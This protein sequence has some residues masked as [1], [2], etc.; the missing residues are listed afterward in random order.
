M[1]LFHRITAIARP[2]I[3]QMIVDRA[4]MNLRLSVRLVTLGGEGVVAVDPS[5]GL[6]WVDAMLADL[7][8]H[9]PNSSELVRRGDAQTQR[10]CRRNRNAGLAG[11]WLQGV[12]VLTGERSGKQTAQGFA[13]AAFGSH[14]GTQG[15]DTA[16]PVEQ[17][18]DA[19]L[20]AGTG[21]GFAAGLSGQR[22]DRSF[23]FEAV[24]MLVGALATGMV[25]VQPW[26]TRTT[27][28]DELDSAP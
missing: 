9:G 7:V 10:I 16:V 23:V 20:V 19:A 24:A 27:N 12:E 6:G 21:P 11:P 28:H 18:G 25:A 13:F 14:R 8:E 3:S 26:A 1:P 2:A 17:S 4:G 5:K 15:V 22:P